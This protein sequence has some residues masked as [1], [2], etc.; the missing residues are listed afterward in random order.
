MPASA[1][2][3]QQ[4]RERRLKA[5]RL[6]AAG[7]TY[8]AIAKACGLKSAAAACVDVTR[9]LADTKLLLDKEAAWYTVL[10]QER[11]DLMQRTIEDA[12]RS[13]A[14]NPQLQM[15]LTDRLLRISQR[16]TRMLGLDAKEGQEQ[17]Q[18]SPLDELR[19]RRDRKR[20]G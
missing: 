4:V 6:R 1:S 2:K 15:Q 12:L 17:P 18:E 11:L 9:A 13:A 8:E 16:R 3:M 7:A 5:L 14:G 19:R 10:E 20:A